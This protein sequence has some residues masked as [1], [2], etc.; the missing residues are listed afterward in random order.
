MINFFPAKKEY[1]SRWRTIVGEVKIIFIAEE[2]F[3]RVPVMDAEGATFRLAGG[4]ETLRF[5]YH[6][7]MHLWRVPAQAG[8]R[9][10]KPLVK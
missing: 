7:V 6:R 4:G 5:Q 2:P 8:H 3:G 9:R 1:R 10:G